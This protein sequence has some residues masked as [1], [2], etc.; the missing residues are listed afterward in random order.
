[1]SRPGP[2]TSTRP[3]LGASERARAPNVIVI[4]AAKT[5]TT[6]LHTYLDLHP[7]ASMSDPKEL[8]FFEHEEDLAGLAAYLEHFDPDAEV[9]GESSPSYAQFPRLEGVPE[10]IRWLNPAVRLIY[11]VRDPVP[12]AVAHWAQMVA[13]ADERRGLTEAFATLEPRENLYVCASSYA[14]QLEYYLRSFD[15]EQVMVID[16][17]RLR[18]DRREVLREVFGFLGI[19]AGFWAPE[20]DREFNPRREQRRRS[21][22]WWSLRS[23]PLGAAFRRLPRGLRSGLRRP[24]D[25]TLSRQVGRPELPSEIRSRLEQALAPEVARLRELTGQRFETWSL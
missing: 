11:L 15:A 24:L 14:T 9:R 7:Q 13:F 17:H 8:K 23:S 1:V 18:H 10:R 19:D 16:Q 6:S 3:S 21:G 12:R 4:G 25:R 2:Q 20:F 5:G 22:L